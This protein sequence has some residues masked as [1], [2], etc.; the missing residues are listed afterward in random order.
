LRTG[1]SVVE[2]HSYAVR[3]R[4]EG[5]PERLRARLHELY[6]ELA[7]ANAIGEKVLCYNDCPRFA[8]GDF[9]ERPGVVTPQEGLVLAGDGI[10][11]DLPVALMERAA[12]TG[13]SAANTL[14]ARFGLCGHA[15]RTV[16]TKG[17]STLLSRLADG[18]RVHHR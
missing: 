12:T 5:I 9:A 4:T 3:P 15:L 11:V 10:R 13:F 7:D 6:P 16:P 1:G 17:R 14:L 8:P 2:L 18:E